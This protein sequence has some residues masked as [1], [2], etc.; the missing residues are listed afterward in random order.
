MRIL[1][2]TLQLRFSV[3]LLTFPVPFVHDYHRSTQLLYLFQQGLD[4][5][6]NPLYPLIDL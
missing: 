6:H 1:V 5:W 2:F 3:R 4:G